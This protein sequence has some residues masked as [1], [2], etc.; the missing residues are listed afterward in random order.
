MR[1]AIQGVYMIL[2]DASDP[3]TSLPR[4]TRRVVS[5]RVP[6]RAELIAEIL[7]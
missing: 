5:P 4:R 6:R 2:A 3:P 7:A 1:S